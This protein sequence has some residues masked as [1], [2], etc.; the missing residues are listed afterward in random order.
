M[1]CTVQAIDLGNIDA[2]VAAVR[3]ITAAAMRSGSPFM[4]HKNR[5]HAPSPSSVCRR[6]TTGPSSRS[7]SGRGMPHAPG[8]LKVAAVNLQTPAAPLTDAAGGG[9]SFNTQQNDGLSFP[10][11]GF[12]ADQLGDAGTTRCV[13]ALN[14]A[15]DLGRCTV[16][17]DTCTTFLTALS[18]AAAGTSIGAVL[19]NWTGCAVLQAA[20]RP[21]S[22][23]YQ[24]LLADADT[25]LDCLRS[26]P[27]RS[28]DGKWGVRC[29]E[30]GPSDLWGLFPVGCTSGECAN[31]G[32]WVSGGSGDVVFEGARFLSE[33]RAGL[34]LPNYRHINSTY[35]STITY[36]QL[37]MPR[38][39]DLNQRRCFDADELSPSAAEENAVPDFSA[40]DEASVLR[41]LFPAAQLVRDSPLVAVCTRFVVEEARAEALSGTPS[42]RNAALQ[43]A[44]WRRRCEAKV[45][46]ASACNLTGVYFGIAP[47]VV[48]DA[49][50]AHCGVRLQLPPRAG[51]AAYLASRGGGDAVYLTP[52]CVLVDRVT[53]LMYD[54]PLCARVQQGGGG[55]GAKG[56]DGAPLPLLLAGWS[57]LSLDACGLRPQPLSLLKGNAP[58]SM[59]YT[60]G[61]QPLS[62]DW[63]SNLARSQ[64]TLD[65][66]D[67][68]ATANAAPSRD[69]VSHVLDW[70][71]P[72]A[73]LKS[74]P[75]FHITAPSD[76][77]ELAPLVFDSHYLYDPV[78]S[79]LFY[80]HSVARN[81]S[82]LYNTLGA[83]GVCRAT[84]VA[85][86]MFDANTNR[87]CTRRSKASDADTPQM[88]VQ[89]LKRGGGPEET[90]SPFSQAYMDRYFYAEQCA[91]SAR[92]VPWSV[93]PTADADPQ[94]ATAGGI[95]GWQRYVTMN[96]QGATSYLY[97]HYP[98][99][100][101]S[102]TSTY[103]LSELYDGG[104]GDG[105]GD[106]HGGGWGPCADTV[107]WGTT[108]LCNPKSPSASAGCPPDVSLCM[109]I[110]DN[111]TITA[112]EMRLL[113]AQGVC[114]ST[115]TYV[116][117]GGERQPCFQTS[118]CAD[119]LVC[120]A[121]GACAPLHLHV[122]NR[123]VQQPTDSPTPTGIG[124][125]EFTVLADACGFQ[126]GAHPYTQSMRGASPWEVV[127]D[128]LHA[129]GFCSHRNWFAYR[130]AL[131]SQT[132]PMRQNN[133]GG[134]SSE[135]AASLPRTGS[136]YIG[137][138]GGDG[139]FLQCNTTEARW[140]WVHA[141]F[142][143]GRSGEP[144]QTMAE[145]HHLL[146]VPHACDTPFM[147]LQ[148][149]DTGRRLQVCSGFQGRSETP[150]RRYDL[151]GSS[152]D[153]AGAS[154][155]LE[156]LDTRDTGRIVS[157]WLRTYDETVGAVHVGV[158]DNDISRDVPL[159]F[160]G[161]VTGSGSGVLN[162][163]ASDRLN[164]VNF[165]RC[166]DRMACSNPSFT[167]N[168]VDVKDRLDPATLAGNF[169]ELSLRL[170]GAIGYTASQWPN[171][172]VGGGVCWLDAQLFPL[173]TQL[174]WGART[175]AGCAA[176][177]SPATALFGG[178]N[179]RVVS[180]DGN[181][182]ETLP[183][184]TIQSAPT[185]LFCE[186]APPPLL[187]LQQSGG[188]TSASASGG[189]C[190]FAARVSTRLT[191]TSEQ[192]AVATLTAFLNGLLRTAGRVVKT[193]A[194]SM[195]R[196]TSMG[197]TRVYEHINRCAAQ[198][199]RT[200]S[201]T[202]SRLQAAYGTAG[203][204]GVYVALRV[205]LYEVPVAWLH[206]A[207][208]VTL[209]SILDP[210]VPEPPL[211]TMG[212][213]GAT[214]PVFLWAEA[215]RAAVCRNQNELNARAVL[216]RLLCLNSHPAY[217]FAVGEPFQAEPSPPLAADQM[218]RVVVLLYA[219]LVFVIHTEWRGRRGR[220]FARAQR[221]ICATTCRAIRGA[222]GRIAT[223]Q[224]HGGAR[225]SRKRVKRCMRAKLHAYSRTIALLSTRPRRVSNAS[226]R[227]C[228]TNTTQ[229]TP[230]RGWTRARRTHGSF[231]VACSRSA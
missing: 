108:T 176:L 229:S 192:D 65:S 53:R 215:D 35:H 33:G 226:W 137:N 216:W 4:W 164:K 40:E 117:S 158:L 121:D 151:N 196:A 175:G 147:H 115:G 212:V 78:T 138:Q 97:A 149:P 182:A 43:A 48:P 217:T 134:G 110:V 12:M 189:R 223:P 230:T 36:A 96:A 86:P 54:A 66:V 199:M 52:G 114:M 28:P 10:L 201:V 211:E 13:C 91:P 146:A 81:A 174:M 154:A 159:G 25:V 141:R 170:C 210:S 190:A 60:V 112:P 208:L 105:D 104:D 42:A 63:L 84:N 67:A 106:G 17:P 133:G 198:L 58:Y 125:M 143:M 49:V 132:C 157:R 206:H 227:T 44:Q 14:H 34:R 26:A 181:A 161:A 116:D 1:V 142:D 37:Q 219:L 79:K 169:S 152:D 74:P 165:F 29:P 178:A 200:I 92:D 167:Y 2:V 135:A 6:H 160:L 77:S 15:S 93:L 94:S 90:V 9:A 183:L 185:T 59:V 184:S 124:D 69:Q 71:S 64:L 209:L 122:W 30:L 8:R 123:M 225:R 171:A 98:P 47:P 39:A 194:T 193:A 220:P 136:N 188:G 3:N 173:F 118:Q 46:Q 120:L 131:W 21:P 207:M 32:A 180:V 50:T 145:G 75:G 18:S 218:V 153:W 144:F 156:A 221:R 168:G 82:L 80:A 73:L 191:A 11:H 166:T 109:P 127:P 95:P 24:Y 103:Q 186:T 203:P 214:I 140:P 155:L 222:H 45:R 205:T 72:T 119:G 41:T 20:C 224:R 31:A 195:P 7:G 163:M 202:Q 87:I 76:P 99:P 197:P 51:D 89:T 107:R 187:V 55:A 100:H 38:P 88:P 162:D 113:P 228:H 101:P 70:W 22:P 177:W 102:S 61:A 204:S 62:T 213:G 57:A 5:R 129:H 16:H 128:L 130:N 150:P 56:A 172:E 231:L 27:L 68:T 19:G 23:A 126:E 85:L 111:T 179:A 148:N 139:A 83:A